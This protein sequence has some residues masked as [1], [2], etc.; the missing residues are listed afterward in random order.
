MYV[1]N[2]TMITN[3]KELFEKKRRMD[4]NG[5]IENDRLA[6]E[7]GMSTYRTI[8]KIARSIT[9]DNTFLTSIRCFSICVDPGL[10]D[11]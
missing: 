9:S 5:E 2:F 10:F 8:I 1:S 6:N 4:V 11:S 7:T 3:V